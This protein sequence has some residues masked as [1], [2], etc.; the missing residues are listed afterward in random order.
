MKKLISCLLIPALL[1]CLVTAAFAADAKALPMTVS[2]A[3]DGVSAYLSGAMSD[4]SY[5]DWSILQLAR[6]GNLNDAMREEYLASVEQKLKDCGGVLSEKN[7]TEYS[8]TIIALTACGANASDF[9]GYDL[10][11]PLGDY[12]KTVSQGVNGAIYA[13]IAMDTAGYT[14]AAD[15]D[16]SRE[17]LVQFILASELSGGGWTYFGSTAD[18][19]LTAMALQA[20]APYYETNSTVEKAVDRALTLLSNTQEADGGY[21]SWGSAC[22]ESPAQVLLALCCL[23]I[24]PAKDE[25]FV[26]ENGAWLGSAIFSYLAEG[27]TVA[28]GHADNK[29]NAMATQQ[30]GYALAAYERLLQGKTSLYDMSDLQ[31]RDLVY[32]GVYDYTAAEAGL[33]HASDSGVVLKNYP[34]PYKEGMTASEAVSAAFADNHITSVGLDAGYISEINGLGSVGGY[35]GWMISYNN[36]DFANWGLSYITPQAGD[37]IEFHYTLNLDTMTDDIGYGWCGLPI[38][39]SFRLGDCEVT[40]ARMPED[41]DN[42]DPAIPC[43]VDGAPIKGSGTQTDPFQITLTLQS[44]DSDL[45]TVVPEY[46]TS[47]NSHYAVIDG[48]K[49]ADFTKPVLCSISSRGGT[50]KSYFQINASV[51]PHDCLR[52]SDVDGHWARESICVVTEKGWMQGDSKTTFSPQKVMNRAMLVTAFYRIAGTPDAGSASFV[53]VPDGTWYTAAVG[54]GQEADLVNGVGKN[55]FAPMQEMTREEMVTFLWRYA[56]KPASDYSLAQYQDASRVSSWAQEAMCWAV[57]TGL[58]QGVT[59][60]RLSPKSLTTRGEMAT[61]LARYFEA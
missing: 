35:S 61:L 53:D 54:W 39:T 28:F 17:K 30:V 1:L 36:D 51:V 3:V 56:G 29:L 37:V 40:L 22:S 27:E 50:S 7:Y 23:G 19:D 16:N 48:L 8:R 45:T 43:Y 25:R 24:D 57:E 26:K 14:F 10:T 49:G 20:L 32:V 42:Y 18:T 59:N 11:A 34:V 44:Y 52:Y 33:E 15:A 55:R 60:T 12:D 9:A 21:V 4:G 58:V 46:T 6:S 47:L 2:E 41:L 38:F 13:L 31:P 5:S